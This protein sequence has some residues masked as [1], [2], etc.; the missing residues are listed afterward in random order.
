MAV[1]SNCSECEETCRMEKL[2]F[3]CPKLYPMSSFL[4]INVVYGAFDQGIMSNLAFRW[5]TKKTKSRV[6]DWLCVT[7]SSSNLQTDSICTPNKARFDMR[8]LQHFCNRYIRLKFTC[9]TPLMNGIMPKVG[10]CHFFLWYLPL[11]IPNLLQA[12][13]RFTKIEDPIYTSIKHGTRLFPIN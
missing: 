2:W 5:R 4:Y 3:R 8:S 7:T 6:V 1:H 9:A 11:P 12:Q 13:T 10:W